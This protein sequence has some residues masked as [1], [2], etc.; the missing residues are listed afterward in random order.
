M[1]ILIENYAEDRER[2][3]LALRR[4]GVRGWVPAQVLRDAI[5]ECGWRIERSYG[6][7]PGLLSL[8]CPEQSLLKIPVDFRRRLWVPETAAAVLNETLARE[9][10]RIRLQ[11]AQMLDGA[12][13]KAWERETAE[14]ARVFL[15]PL[16]ALA[17]RMPMSK[18]VE[19]ET[20]QQ[21]W[22]QV[23]RLAEE[24]RVTSW[25]M[26]CALRMYGM[27]WMGQRRHIEVL[28]EAQSVVGR[29]AFA[30]LA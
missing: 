14:Y 1:N 20:Q 28:P 16:V 25:F 2:L 6:M 13:K 26:A 7:Q 3:L 30:R 18:L 4:K 8:F 9:L 24:F 11:P 15:V 10:G 17:T 21:R 23:S 12:K 27:I 5:L 22:T 19:A 29:Y